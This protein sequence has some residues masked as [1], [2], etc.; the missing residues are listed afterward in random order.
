[1]NTSLIPNSPTIFGMCNNFQTE[2][3]GHLIKYTYC[4]TDKIN[5]IVIIWVAAFLLML[6]NIMFYLMLTKSHRYKN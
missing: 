4:N 5:E 2:I 6:F 1:M 3:D